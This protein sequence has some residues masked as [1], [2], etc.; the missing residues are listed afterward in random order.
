[1]V[2]DDKIDSIP[3][4]GDA[5]AETETI[6]ASDESKFLSGD[7]PA[8]RERPWPT[9]RSILL[10]SLLSTLLL[11]FFILGLS[12]ST[13]TDGLITQFNE[14]NAA[15]RRPTTYCGSSPEEARAAG[16]KFDMMSFGWVA[17]E[18]WDQELYDEM[19]RYRTWNWTTLDG[20]PISTDEIA[21]GSQHQ[22]LATWEFHLVHCVYVWRKLARSV[23]RGRPLDEFAARYG[24]AKH[25]GKELLNGTRFPAHFM[26]TL[27]TVWYPKCGLSQ[28]E[29]L[30]LLT[31]TREG[32]E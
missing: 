15:S 22:A 21:T 30:D 31:T 20:Q 24:H 4:L 5:S 14:Q 13:N 26:N 3:L 17:P 1:M 11:L 7:A 32:E 18:C 16:C 8:A 28:V 6:H 9:C 2:L 12:V 25:C 23:L 29:M 19:A 10:F 27:T